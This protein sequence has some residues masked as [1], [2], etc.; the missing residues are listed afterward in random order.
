[1]TL[2]DLRSHGGEHGISTPAML[3][4]QMHL[5]AGGQVIVFLNRRGYAPS[6]FC[7]SCGW[8]APCAH[9]DARMTL[10][11]RAQALRCHHCGAQRPIPVICGN[12]GQA[13]NPVGFGTERIEE[14]LTR[15]FP[16]MRESW[17]ALRCSPRA[18]T[19]RTSAWW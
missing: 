1:M 12:C 7:N 18:I 16:A 17:W 3:A 15:L 4:M 2:I 11:L 8:I 9:C 13:L 6:L 10:H 5:K 14:T 19:S